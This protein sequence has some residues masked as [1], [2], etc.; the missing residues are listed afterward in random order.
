MVIF[1]HG[2]DTVRLRGHLQKLMTRFREERDP[3]GMNVS[4]VDAAFMPF[5]DVM[6]VMLAVPFLGS[7][8]MVVVRNAC[9]APEDVQE[10]FVD[11]LERLR[12][13]EDVIIFVHENALE[14]KNALAQA[15]AKE[16]YA[17]AFAAPEGDALQTWIVRRVT[18]LGGTIAVDAVTYLAGAIPDDMPCLSNRVH[19]LVRAADGAL[20]TVE[21]ATSL[22]P[23]R[24]ED[25]VFALMD[26]VVKRDHTTAL[27]LLEQQ[28][29][30]RG[31]AQQ[32]FGMLVRQF[33][34]MA[35]ILSYT[36]THSDAKEADMAKALS[37]HPYVVKKTRSLM[38]GVTRASVV[39]SVDA[40]LTI[41]EKIKRGAG[42]M[43]E[44]LALFIREQ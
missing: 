11:R 16:Q 5:A 9:T 1:L 33:R 37:L 25:V 19:Q 8:R 24:G 2:A 43:P 12:A 18:E 10:W 28:W 32:L 40:L 44:L 38:R 15:L 6:E 23:E 35:D 34:I 39:R 31:D 17:I 4:A 22:V 13:D 7:R 29:A 41:D 26:A 30:Y 21:N 14:A 36:A 27:Q 42:H 20:I 3:S